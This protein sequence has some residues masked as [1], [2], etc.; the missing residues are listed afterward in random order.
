M[1]VASDMKTK[2]EVMADKGAKAVDKAIDKA[3]QKFDNVKDSAAE[4]YDAGVDKAG[5]LHDNVEGYIKD[6]PF[7]SVL[8][9]VGA[10]LLIGMFLGKRS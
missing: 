5:E 7:K 2:T 1:D 4:M 3:Q 6:Q 8:I 9:A 10:G